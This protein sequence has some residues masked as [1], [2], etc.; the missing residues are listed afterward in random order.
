M[1]E[2][3][4]RDLETRHRDGLVRAVKACLIHN[5]LSHPPAIDLQVQTAATVFI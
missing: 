4:A 5:T 3:D 2:V 1:I